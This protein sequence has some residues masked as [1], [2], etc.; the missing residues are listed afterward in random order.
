MKKKSRY[1]VKGTSDS[2]MDVLKNL[3]FIHLL[4]TYFNFF[5]FEKMRITIN[6]HIEEY[7]RK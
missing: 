5:S 7:D 2:F 6:I 4:G 1:T 3:I